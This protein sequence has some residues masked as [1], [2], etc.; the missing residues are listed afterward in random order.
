[1]TSLPATAFRV[2][3]RGLLRAGFVGDVI[4]FDPMK[5]TDRAT[6]EKPHEY[7]EGFTYVFVNGELVLEKGKMTGKLPGKP[8]PGPGISN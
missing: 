2:L 1:M 8:V 5:V 6:F 3:D 7:A 4:I